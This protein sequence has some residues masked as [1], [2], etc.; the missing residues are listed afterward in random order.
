[1]TW[2]MPSSIS[3]SRMS[4]FLQCPLRFRIESMQGLAG[5]TNAPAVAGQTMHA[6]LEGLMKRP[7]GERTVENLAQ[8][9]EHCLEIVKTT[10]DYLSLPE[11][12]LKDFDAKCRR[13]TP[14]AF[15]MLPLAQIE[16]EDA[17]LDLTVDVEGWTLHGIIDLVER[18][19]RNLLICHDYKTGKTPS[20]RFQH[21]S[22]MGIDFYSV[23][24][25][26]HYGEVP[27]KI[28]LLYLDSRTTI[29]KVPTER[30]VKAMKMKIGAVRTALQR[31][32]D[33]DSFRP[34]VSKLCDWCQAKPY[35][36]AHGGD[37]DAVPVAIGASRPVVS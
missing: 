24:L 32:C 26:E 29:T 16:V 35:C 5:G 15:D 18:D 11:E 27:S 28:D 23:L 20:E 7:P 21:K 13:I 22:M 31:A 4:L 1:M 25:T 3:P 37:P 17:E 33:N 14:R 36:P 6:A 30:S 8:H 34:S 2:Q 12:D 10:E 19:Q 9:V